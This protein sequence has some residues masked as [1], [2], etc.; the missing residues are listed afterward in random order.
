[1]SDAV[2]PLAVIARIALKEGHRDAAIEL[3]QGLVAH[4][5][6]EAG[7]ITYILHLD[8]KDTNLLWFYEQYAGEGALQ[9]HATSE[10]MAAIGPKLAE[11]LAGRAELTYLTPVVAAG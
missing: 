3:L 11:H 1:M 6:T 4:A 8:N 2:P 5:A 10:F 9:A 7:T